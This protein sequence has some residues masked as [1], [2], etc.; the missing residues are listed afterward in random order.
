MYETTASAKNTTRLVVIAIGF[1]IV[2]VFLAL[3]VF[4]HRQETW[5]L[6]FLGS[7][8][9]DTLIKISFFGF[10]AVLLNRL[11]T[12][13]V[14]TALALSS[15]LALI[16]YTHSS[17]T[18]MGDSS[19]LWERMTREVRKLQFSEI[20]GDFLQQWI[21][22]E[23]NSMSYIVLLPV[24]AGF[25]TFFLIFYFLP[26]LSWIG[27]KYSHTLPIFLIGTGMVSLFIFNYIETTILSI[28]LL[29]AFTLICLFALDRKSS[30][31]FYR[32]SAAVA[33]AAATLF[34]GQNLAM[35]PALLFLAF[36]CSGEVR[37]L[38][39]LKNIS[40]TALIYLGAFITGVGLIWLTGYTLEIGNAGGG[41]D[42]QYSMPIIAPEGFTYY[43]FTMFSLEHVA[44]FGT[45]VFFAAPAALTVPILWFMGRKE[46]FNKGIY[47]SR[48][49][50]GLLFLSIQA[51]LYLGFI[52][53]YNFDLG[54]Y[55]FDLMISMSIG[56]NLFVY[57]FLLVFLK[58]R[59]WIFYLVVIAQIVI[60]SYLT[61]D[62]I[63][64]RACLGFC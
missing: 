15:T 18:S 64:P 2:G 35:L 13:R 40:I 19:Q 8:D 36:S 39:K 49:N 54:R 52:F 60:I 21:S 37:L 5:I 9:A 51:V 3:T 16:W 46:I 33:L 57:Y 10:L 14:V 17:Q 11:K 62:L 63:E 59:P 30:S 1:G 25:A 58:S 27:E 48:D 4:R 22:R 12:P 47:S 45:I 53:L 31:F 44:D 43:R 7:P 20:Y 23:L 24:L 50:S 32:F 29:T 42:W 61:A 6:S 28:P 41:G 38:V 56:L 26:G 34:H 55:D